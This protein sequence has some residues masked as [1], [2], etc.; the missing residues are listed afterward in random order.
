MRS[1][2]RPRD[3]HSAR[4]AFAV[5][6]IPSIENTAMLAIPSKATEN[7]LTIENLQLRIYFTCCKAE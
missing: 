2:I 5:V 7:F 6:L 3:C 4:Q 1:V